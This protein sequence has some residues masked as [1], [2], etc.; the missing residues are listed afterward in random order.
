MAH[1]NV[2]L[3]N[4]HLVKHFKLVILTCFDVFLSEE[5]PC[6]QEQFLLVPYHVL[7]LMQ[8]MTEAEGI[9]E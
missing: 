9:V 8:Y 4:V 2:Y 1:Y 6:F 7:I 5:S 3:E